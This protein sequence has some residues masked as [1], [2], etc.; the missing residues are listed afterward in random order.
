MRAVVAYAGLLSVTACNTTGHDPKSDPEEL[1]RQVASLIKQRHVSE[2]AAVDQALGVQ[3]GD[4]TTFGIGWTRARVLG[5]FETPGSVGNYSYQTMSVNIPPGRLPGAVLEEASLSLRLSG[6]P[7]V[8]P[9]HVRRVFSGSAWS[10]TSSMVK[11]TDIPGWRPFPLMVA[12]ER[13]RSFVAIRFNEG[14]DRCAV[15]ARLVQN[16]VGE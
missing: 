9:D 8:R 10:V 14:L 13:N 16:W 3:I 7:C 2:R 12:E 11:V 15:S 4:G 1:L 5:W 6:G